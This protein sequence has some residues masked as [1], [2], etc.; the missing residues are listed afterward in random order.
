VEAVAPADE[1]ETG[2]LLRLDEIHAV[3]FV[4]EGFPKET[5]SVDALDGCLVLRSWKHTSGF[6]FV[7]TF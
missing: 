4:E 6:A 1:F 5:D 2:L 7:E 3:C